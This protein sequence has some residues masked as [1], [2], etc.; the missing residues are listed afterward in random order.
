[1]QNYSSKN[2]KETE[3]KQRII[4]AIVNELGTLTIKELAEYMDLPVNL[5][6]YHVCKLTYEQLIDY[7]KE[8]ARNGQLRVRV[9]KL[10]QT[11]ARRAA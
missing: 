1:M 10:D 11:A 3:R 6:H 4:L 7:K 8:P 5:V 9:S 2:S